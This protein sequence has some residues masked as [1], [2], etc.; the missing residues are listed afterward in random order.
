MD[1]FYK[2]REGNRIHPTLWN[3]DVG[4]ALRGL[5][6]VTM[7]RLDGREILL[8]YGAHISATLLDITH[9]TTG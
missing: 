5:D 9:E 6:E 2:E 3:D 4:V 1:V 7:H 8:Q